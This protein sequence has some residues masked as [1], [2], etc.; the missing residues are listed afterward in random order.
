M[1]ILIQWLIHDF[2]EGGPYL[3]GQYQSSVWNI[4]LASHFNFNSGWISPSYYYNAMTVHFAEVV[5]MY[6]NVH[7]EWRWRL[8]Q[9]VYSVAEEN[10]L[11]PSANRGEGGRVYVQKGT[12]QDKG[13]YRPYLLV[14]PCTHLKI[15]PST[16]QT[17]GRCKPRRLCW[18]TWWLHCP[19]VCSYL[20]SCWLGTVLCK[21][22]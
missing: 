3:G 22:H 17:W 8:E 20:S 21:H 2:C 15:F 16:P 7:K 19:S 18:L 13:K 10:M 4:G 6:L 11:V 5:C 9:A 1:A 14:C 12:C